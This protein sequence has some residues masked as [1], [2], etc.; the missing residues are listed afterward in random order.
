MALLGHWRIEDRLACQWRRATRIAAGW[1]TTIT[2]AALVAVDA[3]RRRRTVVVAATRRLVARREH[4]AAHGCSATISSS[5]ITER[6]EV[7]AFDV[8]EVRSLVKSNN[9]SGNAI[10]RIVPEGTTVKKGDFLVE[11]D[12]SALASQRTSQKILV[13]DAKAAR[14]R[15][16]QQLR[17]GRHRQARVSRRHVSAGSA[18]DRK[19]VVRRRGESQSGEGVLH[20]QPEAGVEGLREREP[21]RGR[22]VRRRE[23]E[24]GSRRGQDEAQGAR[25]VHEAQ[26]GVDA[27]KRDPDRQSQV[28]RGSEQRSARR[29]RSCKIS[30]T[31][32][33]SAR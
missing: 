33:P 20:V 19:R 29:S 8:T 24:Q 5:T 31:R 10:L 21:T 16:P 12:S 13:N 23:G 3:C 7:E 9:T 26:A 1:L 15:G 11:L 6:G 28:G 25:R 2:A 18:G 32:S 22:S 30:T 17:R 27:G 4:P 14:G